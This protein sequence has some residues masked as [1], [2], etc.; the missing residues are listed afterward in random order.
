MF[1]FNA[2]MIW[3]FT[4]ILFW[5]SVADYEIVCKLGRGKYS[6]V[7]EGIKTVTGE[8]TVI[9]I[10]KV[11]FCSTARW[12]SPASTLHCT[13]TTL[14]ANTL[15]FP[16]TL[17]LQP[18]K[19]KKIKREIKILQNLCGGVNIIQLLDVVHDTTT[20]DSAGE[21]EGGDDACYVSYVCFRLYLIKLK[22]LLMCIFTALIFAP[23]D[24]DTCTRLRARQQYRF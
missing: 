16:N 6:E 20:E 23:P 3:I 22:L 1:A 13:L 15:Y 19:K 2:K 12:L 8:K 17:F 18:V 10:L 9:K 21:Q 11:R 24:E 4:N 14:L 7:F 5:R